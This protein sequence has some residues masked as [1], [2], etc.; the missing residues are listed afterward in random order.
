MSPVRICPVKCARYCFLQQISD[1]L[2]HHCYQFYNFWPILNLKPCHNNLSL[3][4]L[5]SSQPCQERSSGTIHPIQNCG[6]SL[7]FVG[8]LPCHLLLLASSV[9]LPPHPSPTPTCHHPLEPSSL[10]SNFSSGLVTSYKIPQ[11]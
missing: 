3:A 4:W 2:I 7:N 10:K 6:E 8:G 11:F 5:S 9:T 1:T